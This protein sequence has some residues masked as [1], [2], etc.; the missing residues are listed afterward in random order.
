MGVY[1][2]VVVE[3]PHDVGE[4]LHVGLLEGAQVEGVESHARASE[5]RLGALFALCRID[6]APR[7]GNEAAPLGLAVG[8]AQPFRRRSSAEAASGHHP[9]HM[10]QHQVALLGLQG[11]RQPDRRLD[12]ALP[13]LHGEP[14]RARAQPLPGPRLQ[15]ADGGHQALGS[16]DLRQLVGVAAAAVQ[17]LLSHRGRLGAQERR[18]EPVADHAAGVL[19]LIP[20][21]G[22]DQP[23][24]R[25]GQ[26]QARSLRPTAAAAAQLRPFRD[27]PPHRRDVVGHL[28][29]KGADGH[30]V[31]RVEGKARACLHLHHAFHE[32][33]RVAGGQGPPHRRNVLG[34][35][36]HLDAIDS[37]HGITLPQS[38]AFDR[39]KRILQAWS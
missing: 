29:S 17:H 19:H 27:A 8:L 2:A 18:P 16:V 15:G 26:G 13:G 10:G 32:Q 9:E 22:D 21:E 20:F 5:E 11:L 31:K 3:Q 14:A 4:A 35:R 30:L 23:W 36:L 7:H 1:P 24:Q 6:Q 38:R 12:Y 25:L 33:A 34:L 28:S 39:E 37:V